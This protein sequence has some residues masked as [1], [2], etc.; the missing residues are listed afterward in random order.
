MQQGVDVQS[1]VEEDQWLPGQV[2][3]GDQSAAG[4]RA[5]PADKQRIA[6]FPQGY[7]LQPNIVRALADHDPQVGGAVQQH[8]LDGVGAGFADGQMQV[9]MGRDKL[10][11]NQRGHK[12]T[13]HWRQT[14]PQ[15]LRPAGHCLYLVYRNLQLDEQRPNPPVKSGSLFGEDQ[16]LAHPPEQRDAQFFLQLPYGCRDGRLG[17]G[18]LPGGG[19]G[20]AALHRLDKVLQLIQPHAVHLFL[21]WKQSYMA[22]L[23]LV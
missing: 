9:R 17:D 13:D 4:Q 5:L 20:S 15:R 11:K 16:L 6:G 22:F 2:P 21:L 3:E 7:R 1:L 23:T 18:K 14:Q 8:L 12:H 19:V 10:P